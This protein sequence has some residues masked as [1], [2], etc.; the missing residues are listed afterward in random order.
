MQTMIGDTADN[1]KGCPGIGI[2]TAEKLF[3]K[4]GATWDTV[5]K[6]FKNAGCTEEDALVQ[7]RVARILRDEDFKD[8]KVKLWTPNT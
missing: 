7:A 6:S 5:V 4:Y 2:K 1:Y 3:N 8:G